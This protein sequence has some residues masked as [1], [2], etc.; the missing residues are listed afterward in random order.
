MIMTNHPKIDELKK[1]GRLPSPKGAA[2]Q[3]LDL[4][5]RDDVTNQEV[6]YAIQADPALSALLI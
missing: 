5:Q 6:A 2:L 4:C 1:S 3:V